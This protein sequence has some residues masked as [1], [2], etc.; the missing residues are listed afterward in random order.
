MAAQIIKIK[1]TTN[2]WKCVSLEGCSERETKV[3]VKEME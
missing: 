2:G 1:V 3:R